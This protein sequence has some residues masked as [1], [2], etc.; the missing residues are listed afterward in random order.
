MVLQRFEEPACSVQTVESLLSLEAKDIDELLA[1]R[2]ISTRA[3]IK[4]GRAE[5][6]YNG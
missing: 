1:P 3:S 2:P 5:G 4:K 6:I